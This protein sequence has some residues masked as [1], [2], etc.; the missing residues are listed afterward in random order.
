MGENSENTFS[1]FSLYFFSF[2]LFFS[3]SAS[4]SALGTFT[5]SLWSDAPPTDVADSFDLRDGDEAGSDDDGV[6]VPMLDRLELDVT[7]RAVTLLLLLE[8]DDG[9]VLGFKNCRGFLNVNP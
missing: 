6:I 4:S 3:P 8:Y 7:D 2:L 5:V 1:A 9:G